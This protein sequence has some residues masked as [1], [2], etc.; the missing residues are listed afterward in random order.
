MLYW[1]NK[2]YSIIHVNVDDV[3]EEKIIDSY[4]QMINANL[5]Y[6]NTTVKKWNPGT[7]DKTYGRIP[8]S[9]K[10]I[11]ILQVSDGLT[12]VGPAWSNIQPEN[13]LNTTVIHAHL[14]ISER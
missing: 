11:V 7:D 5:T 10:Y 9:T 13:M 8:G 12:K 3:K 1:I 14:S 2:N 6:I 4:K